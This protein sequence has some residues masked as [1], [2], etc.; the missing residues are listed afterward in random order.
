MSGDEC[1]LSFLEEQIR[2]AAPVVRPAN[3]LR[4]QILKEIVAEKNRGRA[5]WHFLGIAAGLL[6][7]SGLVLGVARFAESDSSPAAK[8]PAGSEWQLVDEF[9]QRAEKSR[10]ISVSIQ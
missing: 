1:E 5:R 10:T 8:A 9:V 6:L 4:S 3:Q 2:S 7:S